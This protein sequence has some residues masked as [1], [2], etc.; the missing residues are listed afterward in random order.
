MMSR[1]L[2][3]PLFS[4]P[5]GGLAPLPVAVLTLAIAAAAPTASRA[6]D[7]YKIQLVAEP[8]EAIYEAG[9]TARLIVSV[10]RDGKP[11]NEGTVSYVVDDFITEA[12]PQRDYPRGEL[13]LSSSTA[14][15][16]SS[17]QPGFLRCRVSF[18]T[19]E[20]KTIT[21]TAA[22]AFS[23]TKIEPSLPVP[24][25]FDAFWAEQKRQLAAVPLDAK[26][27]PVAH[28]DSSVTCFDVQVT[29]VGDVPVSGYLA[30]PVDAKPK[31][32]PAVLW[33]HGAGVRSSILTT[34]VS[35]AKAGMLSMD[36]NAHGIENG[37]PAQFYEELA[38]GPLNNYRHAGREDREQS[39]FRGMFLRLVRAI[40]FLTAQPEWDGRVVAVIGHSQGGGQALAAGGLDERVTFIGSGVPAICDHSG[41]A[42]GRV[43]GWPKLVPVDAQGTPDA[44]ILEASRYFDAVNFASRCRAEA[45]MS[46]GFI[47]AT[48]PPSSCYAAYNQLLG[49]KEM[50]DE[51]LMGHAGPAHIKRAFFER[52]QQHVVRSG[53][54]A[55]TA[56]AAP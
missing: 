11:V 26:L 41:R 49:E 15:T 53:G 47:D 8:A 25:D 48:C 38:A 30:K 9:E 50:I 28:S 43:N 24:D 3:S 42:A 27:T 29:C 23:P 2:L 31:S 22:A 17:Q 32:L 34:A 46:V 54:A 1:S 19:P 16:F 12:P 44:T 20:K 14:V 33:V 39:Y 36:I 35:G 21:A 45:I 51:P 18:R 5:L 52:L 10:T 56:A 37:K 6:Q 13:D 55:P 7:N 40:D 4:R